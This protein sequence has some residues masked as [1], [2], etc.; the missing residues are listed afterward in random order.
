MARAHS[1]QDPL[2][3]R[4]INPESS[5]PPTAVAASA[6]R[7][8]AFAVFR[9]DRLETLV[10]Q[11][12]GANLLSARESPRQGKTEEIQDA[13]N[14]LKLQSFATRSCKS[15]RFEIANRN[16]ESKRLPL[17]GQLQS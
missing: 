6:H 7:A 14:C 15:Y 13:A 1:R 9:S 16:A 11:T 17:A 8:G 12:A 10:R 3:S 4:P 2:E 5:L